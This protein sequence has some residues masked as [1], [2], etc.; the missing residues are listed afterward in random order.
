KNT[1]DGVEEGSNN[2][3]I[4]GRR[5]ATGRPILAND[6]HRVQQTP[7]LR[8]ISHLSAPGMNVIGAGEPAL[9]GISIG[10][11]ESIA[12]GL[13]VFGIDAQ[14]LYV[15]D[16]DDAN[17]R[18]RYKGGWLPLRTE[19]ERVGVRGGDPEEV[20]LRYTR[21]GPVIFVDEAA[22]KAYAVRSTW[23]EPGTSAYF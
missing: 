22:H 7:S 13:T 8:Y 12:F 6:P 19:K 17:E 16:L 20:T 21:H 11:N 14:D 9:P 4:A 2:W 15:Y 1:G 5:T 18:Y 3:T 23:S 10:H